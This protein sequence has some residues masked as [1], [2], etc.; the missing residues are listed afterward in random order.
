MKELKLQVNVP[1]PEV[2]KLITNSEAKQIYL[3]MN[4]NI[5]IKTDK[6]NGDNNATISN[7]NFVSVIKQKIYWYGVGTGVVV[8]IVV[9]LLSS[10]IYDLI[11]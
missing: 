8:S 4:N 3:T 11:K 10:F 1:L 2:I 9:D 6:Q 7:H 5:N